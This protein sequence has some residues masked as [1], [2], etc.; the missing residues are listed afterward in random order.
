MEKTKIGGDTMNV[1]PLLYTPIMQP[2]EKHFLHAL[3][4]KHLP[5]LNGHVLEIG[6][7]PGASFPYYRA[8][9]KVTAIEPNDR[10][11]LLS[12][13]AQLRAHVPIRTLGASAE[14]LPFEENTF[15]SV[16]CTLVLC[17]VEDPVRVLQELKRVCK[18]GATA[19]FLEHV[20]MAHP[21]AARLQRSIT[22]VWKHFCDGCHLDRPT[23]SY[24][25][26]A[27]WSITHTE[28]YLQGFLLSMQAG[29]PSGPSS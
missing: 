21:A 19:Y 17:S 11:R 13:P 2:V 18:P 7:G 28:A 5:S 15:D 20:Q 6:S 16:V 23:H 25:E 1:F 14:R 8:A 9:T 22:P 24:I 10:M 4:Q 29:L 27:G 12:L 3:R 26:Q